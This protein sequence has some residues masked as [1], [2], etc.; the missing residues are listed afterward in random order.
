MTDQ[1][2]AMEQTK[3]V[4]STITVR[5]WFLILMMFSS[6]QVFGQI[7]GLTTVT[8]GQSK[9]YTYTDDAVTSTPTWSAALGVVTSTSQAGFTYSA[10]IFWSSPGNSDVTFSYGAISIS[11]QVQVNCSG[12]PANPSVTWNPDPINCAPRTVT[13]TGAPP[14]GV[15]WYWV[16]SPSG[17]ETAFPASGA[18]V[19]YAG[20]NSFYLRAQNNSTGC[21]SAG[22]ASTTVVTNPSPGTPTSP[23]VST[24]TCGAKT[25]T[26]GTPPANITWYWQTAYNGT[27]TFDNSVTYS[28]TTTGIYYLR[29]R[30][31]T[32]LC[33]GT[34][35][36]VSV[37]VNDAPIPTYPTAS[38]N[39]CGPKTITVAGSPPAGVNWY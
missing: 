11:L 34:A 33:W 7:S 27:N 28:A 25:I 15:T 32:T 31:N 4:K 20:T 36:G 16:S 14:A 26:R 37:T 5:G 23:T 19:A 9:V 38:T 2:T 10:T 13:Y 24:N 17:T 3:G 22:V 6:Y 12:M 18:T 1:A 29:G 30:D 35:T 21:W 39:S 8:V